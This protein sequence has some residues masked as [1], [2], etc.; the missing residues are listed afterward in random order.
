MQHLTLR[1]ETRETETGV[2]NKLQLLS[3]S[4][5]FT[6]SLLTPKNLQLVEYQAHLRSEMQMLRWNTR[7]STWKEPPPTIG[8]TGM[9][10]L[11]RA[12][13]CPSPHVSIL[14]FPFFFP[15]SV[16]APKHS[17]ENCRYV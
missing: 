15:S 10:G 13:S 8:I 5:H 6:N 3:L 2:G 14:T 17:H 1:D 12:H 9:E 7:H 11:L 16:S 4:S